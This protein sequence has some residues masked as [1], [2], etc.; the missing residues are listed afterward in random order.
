LGFRIFQL[1]AVDLRRFF[2]RHQSS[3]SY[4]LFSM[5]QE[6]DTMLSITCLAW[7]SVL[8][9]TPVWIKGLS[10]RSPSITASYRHFGFKIPSMTFQ[11]SRHPSSPTN[12]WTMETPCPSTRPSRRHSSITHGKHTK[13]IRNA[14]HHGRWTLRTD[15]CRVFY[16]GFRTG[17]CGSLARVFLGKVRFLSTFSSSAFSYHSLVVVQVH[18]L[19]FHSASI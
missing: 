4:A 1:L 13:H 7:K 5:E 17:D 11:P 12:T 2:R 8:S 10:L 19:P 18:H 15:P 6:Y 3:T 9:C 14:Y 16:S